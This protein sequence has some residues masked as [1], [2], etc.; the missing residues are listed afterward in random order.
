MTAMR[1][2]GSVTIRPMIAGQRVPDSQS[3]F[4]LIK[5]EVLEKIELKSSNYE[6]ESEMI[7]K[8][9]RAGFKIESVGIKTIYQGEISRIHPFKDSLRFIRFLIKV[10]FDR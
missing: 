10:S 9:A 7:I 3:G 6:I 1:V 5:R 8:A 2:S 4:R